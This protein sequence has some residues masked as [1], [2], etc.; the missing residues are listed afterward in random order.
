M[1]AV[2]RVFGLVFMAATFVAAYNF[3]ALGA[4]AEPEARQ[5]ACAGRGSRCSPALT[6]L[7]RTPLWQDLSFRLAG[8][9]VNVRCARSAYLFGE[10]RCVV[11]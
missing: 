1:R 7:L 8:K 11:R 9:T 4:R 2:V 6:R 5:A 3:F 10:Y